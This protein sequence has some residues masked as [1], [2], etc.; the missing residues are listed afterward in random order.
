MPDLAVA[1][2]DAEPVIARARADR[3]RFRRVRVDLPGR[4]F[5]PSDTPR[6][7]LLFVG[8]LDAQKGVAVLLESLAHRR[9]VSA[10]AAQTKR[11]SGQP[12]ILTN[13]NQY[14]MFN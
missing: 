14:L 7:G 6:D 12:L 13:F 2:K 8:K 3:R 5:T 10:L 1:M 11:S 4:L 9:P